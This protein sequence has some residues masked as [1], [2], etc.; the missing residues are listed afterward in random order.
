[1]EPY[2]QQLPQQSRDKPCRNEGCNKIIRWDDKLSKFIETDTGEV[3]KC[4]FWKLNRPQQQQHG[5]NNNSCKGKDSVRICK[6]C[7]GEITFHDDRI[8]PSGKKIP[9]NLDDTIH[10]C[11]NNPY[12]QTK[13]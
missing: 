8:A 7:N 9:L 1:M 11:K 6:Y 5:P 4:R 2:H 3:H 10:D 13:K 12:N